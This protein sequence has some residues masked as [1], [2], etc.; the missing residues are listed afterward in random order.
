[1]SAAQGA[2]VNDS[3]E[4]T[5]PPK[6][7]HKA[8]AAALGSSPTLDVKPEGLVTAIVSVTGVKDEVN[9]ILE[10]GCYTETLKKRR[11]KVIRAHNWSEQVGRVVNI[12]EWMPGD[13]RLPR[14]TKDGQPWPR[15]AGA[16]V[17]TFQYNMA[18]ERGREAFEDVRFYSETKEAEYSIGY[19]VPAGSSRR[20][21]DGIRRVRK[22]DLYEISDV[23]FGAAPLS[24]TLALKSA[25]S[26]A[27]EPPAADEPAAAPQDAPAEDTPAEEVPEPENPAPEA[28]EATDAETSDGDLDAEVAALHAAA[29]EE[30]DWDLVA[31][32]DPGENREASDPAEP[33]APA[34]EPAQPEEPAELEPETPAEDPAEPAMV[35]ISA[36]EL[37]EGLALLGESDLAE[38]KRRFTAADGNPNIGKGGKGGAGAAKK[39]SVTL[40]KIENA[41][42]LAA[43][44]KAVGKDFGARLKVIAAARKLGLVSKLPKE[45]KVTEKKDAAE[46]QALDEPAQEPATELKRKFTADQR[47]AAAGKGAAMDDGSFPIFSAEDLK[48][49]IAALGR[50]K[51][52]SAARAHI[53][54]RAR[55]LKLTKLLPGDWPESA[56]DGTKAALDWAE[57]NADLVGDMASAEVKAGGADRN[58]GQ[59][60]QLRR[61]YV[62]GG[63]AAEIRWGEGGDWQR[64]VDIAAKHMTPENARGYCELR[65]QE[66]TGMTTSQHAAKDR[67]AHGKKDG[68]PAGLEAK[69]MAWDPAAEVGPLAAHR[70]AAEVKG[71]AAWGAWG[72][73]GDSL[74]TRRERVRGEVVS[75]LSGSPDDDG[76][77]EWDQVTLLGT[78]PDRVIARREQWGDDGIAGAE[79]FEVGY[80]LGEDGAVELGN[81]RPV[82]VD[83]S[84]DPS[85]DATVLQASATGALEDA[86]ASVKLLFGQEDLQVKEGRVLSRVNLKK[87]Q[88]AVTALLTVLAAAGVQIDQPSNAQVKDEAQPVAS[89]YMPIAADTTSQGARDLSMAG[90]ARKDAQPGEAVISP[91]ELA[92][93]LALLSEVW[94]L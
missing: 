67:A 36:E 54:K 10:P 17:A 51:N 2:L 37:A 84:T 49:A 89:E 66:A 61:W 42:D 30:I 22:V 58:R 45:W 60:E 11:P 90:I 65:H 31:R 71:A 9:D 68:E 8:A 44:I 88:D 21:S 25:A 35:T 46:D 76:R 41:D 29:T 74:E 70:P 48:N 12:E 87:L 33:D 80:T 24:M 73:T 43:A 39:P 69:L 15:A 5:E 55:A 78:W 57:E 16:L 85:F 13:S 93:G 27:G 59:A 26:P 32:S 92:A 81:P 75:L 53:A 77:Y 83:V 19:Q 56:K 6:L 91:D 47:T 82:D 20:G 1:M 52:V 38:V 23:L 40:P 64:C 86:V 94:G 50:A 4:M 7:L 63:G 28:P 62:H 34:A 3:L 72:E 79:S 14:Q 18:T